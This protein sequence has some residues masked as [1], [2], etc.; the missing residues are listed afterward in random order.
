MPQVPIYLNEKGVAKLLKDY[1]E[2]VAESGLA[3][4]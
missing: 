3:T 4:E 1:P 2:V